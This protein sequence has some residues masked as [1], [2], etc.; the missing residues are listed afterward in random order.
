M[1]RLYLMSTFVAVV[2]CNGLSGAARKLKLSPAAVTR[3]IAE[4]EQRL[5]VQLLT[6]T[7]RVVRATDAGTLYAD[8]CRRILAEGEDADAAPAVADACPR[9]DVTIPA[10]VLFGRMFVA[11]LVTE[12]L[13]Q[14]PEVTAACWFVDRVVNM[15]DEG[16]DAAVRI[17]RLPDSSLHAHRV[18][19]VRQIV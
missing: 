10:P 15:V 17:G 2:D 6:R 19:Q 16:V 4:L 13:R 7:T 18:G 1:D 14:N 11:P 3:A 12:Y 9:G 8:E 5:G